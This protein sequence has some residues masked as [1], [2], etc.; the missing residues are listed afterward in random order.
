MAR[1]KKLTKRELAVL[2]RRY[3]GW[4]FNNDSAIVTLR[5]KQQADT[6]V[7]LLRLSVRLAVLQF[8][9]V[10][11]ITERQLQVVIADPSSPS[12]QAV[13]DSIETMTTHGG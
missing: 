6:V 1:K 11:T 7:F 9:P 13:M 10:I 8:F 5:F 4:Q 12:A 3:S 2:E